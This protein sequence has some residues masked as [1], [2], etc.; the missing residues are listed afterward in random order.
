MITFGIVVFVAVIITLFLLSKF[1]VKAPLPDT[2]WGLFNSRKAVLLDEAQ[3]KKLEGV[4][5]ITQGNDFFGEQA[6]IKWSC[7][8]E[9]G[10]RVHHLSILL[11]QDAAYFI[12]RAKR[13]KRRILI[14]GYWSKVGTS[15]TGRVRLRI[16]ARKGAYKVFNHQLLSA[17]NTITIAA[18]YDKR[19]TLIWK[20]IALQYVRP[21]ENKFPFQIL[22]HRGAGR[23]MD[24]YPVSENSLES[25]KM[26]ALLGASGLEIDVRLTADNI[27]VLFHDFVLST[28]SVEDYAL[29]QLLNSKT[30]EELQ[31]LRLKKGQ[32]IPTLRD[33]LDFIL[34]GT[35]LEIIWLDIKYDGDLHPI[36]EIIQEYHHKAN[37]ANRNL[38]IYFGIPDRAA[39]KNFIQLPHYK[40]IPS[41]IELDVEDA[42]NIDADIWAP[43]WSTFHQEDIQRIRQ[44]KRKIFTWTVDEPENIKHFMFVQK[45]DGILSNVPSLVAFYYYTA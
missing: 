43:K 20:K 37:E 30:Y 4:Y 23:N 16:T 40:N 32:R 8:I 19:T 21:L 2:R 41:L 11:E 10:K 9:N 25:V 14:N 28:R 29:A 3:N 17:E 34:S 33:A 36:L 35:L 45:L 5:L 42:A 18:R 1:Q 24:F 12:C 7:T 44:E 6:V 27:P 31:Q 39:L 22:A 26:T 13:F 15:E 38:K